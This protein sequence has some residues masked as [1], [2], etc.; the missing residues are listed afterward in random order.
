MAITVT[1]Q[2]GGSTAASLLLRVFV[3]TG[4]KVAAQQTGGT[5][6]GAATGTS[7]T[8]SGTVQQSTSH[9][10]G[11]DAVGSNA[12]GTV[13]GS[14]STIV[15]AVQDATNGETYVTFKNNSPSTGTQS[16]GVTTTNSV[17][18]NVAWLE[19]LASGTI[20]ESASAP[21]EVDGSGTTALSVTTA[22][23]TPPGGS[24]LVAIVSSDGGAGTTTMTV[25]GGSLSW[26]EAIKNNSPAGVDY[27]GVWIA[28]GPAAAAASAGPSYSM[29][30]S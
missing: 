25:S 23:F 8:P 14:N 1:A 30:L 21:P 4:A 29:R 10:Y 26:T 20:T 9:I 11:A 3:L 19:V 27:A 7:E 15:D 6:T 24:L 16:I 22:S 13:S 5:G 17:P 2:Q 18:H 28:D 12:P